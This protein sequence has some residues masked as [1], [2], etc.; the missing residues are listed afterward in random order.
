VPKD[1]KRAV[2]AVVFCLIHRW[3][4]LAALHAE[5]K[6]LPD[7]LFSKQRRVKVFF[8]WKKPEPMLI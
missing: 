3:F 1:L 2:V 6:T 7:V 8:I 4:G 5:V